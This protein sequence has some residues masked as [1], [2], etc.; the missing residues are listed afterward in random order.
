MQSGKI[1]VVIPSFNRCAIT[2]A[3]IESLLVQSELPDLIILCDS[4]STDG[5]QDLFRKYSA[6]TC[7]HLSSDCWWS[8]AVNAGIRKSLS[9]GCD[10]TIILND[11]V[12]FD[13]D[14]IKNLRYWAERYK[15]HI[16]SPFQKTPSGGYA[17]II[18]QSLFKIPRCVNRLD[19]LE[20]DVDVSNGCCL[21]IPSEAFN[22][23][24]LIN[25]HD[26]PHLG[27]DHAFQL[28]CK[29]KG[30]LTKA[31]PTP[32]IEQTFPTNYNKVALVDAFAAINSPFNISIYKKMGRLI[33]GSGFKHCL[34]GFFRHL[35]F[36]KQY[37]TYL[38]K[39]MVYE[40]NR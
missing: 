17:G 34:F 20:I 36:A 2:Q 12:L 40:A 30:F 28:A 24:G 32:Q 11:D 13:K 38:L 31:V 23:A 25:E 18:Y 4:G 3:C 21:W 26:F 8:A 27:G 14:L 22:R 1:S 5:T 19:E 15:D 16:I 7:L 9:E 33:Y 29:G 10:A 6:L 39:K 37:V 35:A